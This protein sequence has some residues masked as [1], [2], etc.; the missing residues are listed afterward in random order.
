MK[1]AILVCA[2]AVLA[3]LVTVRV[4]ADEGI[5]QPAQAQELQPGS[6][7]T[8]AEAVTTTQAV[9]TTTETTTET[10]ITE[11]GPVTTP[12]VMTGPATTEATTTTVIVTTTI[13]ITQ[14]QI[15]SETEPA[16]QL[17]LTETVGPA[18]VTFNLD[19]GYT[20]DPILVSVQAGGPFSAAGLGP[21]CSG[22]VAGAPTASVEWS[23]VADF[24]EFFFISDDDPTLAIQTPTG[25]IFCND[26]PNDVLLDP[27]I[28]IDAPPPGL[29]HIWVGSYARSQRIPGLLVISRNPAQ[30]IG[31][32][33]LEDFIQREPIP[34]VV[35]EPAQVRATSLP[36]ATTRLAETGVPTLQPG[37]TPVNA[38]VTVAGVIAAFD[39]PIRGAVCPGFINSYIDYSFTWAGTTPNLR[40]LFEGDADASLLVVGP[41]DTVYC[42]DDVAGK[43]NLNP[44]ANIVNP[45]AGTYLVYVGRIN[46]ELTVSGMLTVV[47]STEQLPAVLTAIR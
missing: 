13:A 18:L 30:N 42:N 2:A 11:T 23:G 37:A 44:M 3:V 45:P 25:Q 15:V 12:P 26:D 31:T 16:I 19:A 20:L 35:V 34:E 28:Q 5:T 33:R 43:E 17:V 6:G 39:L 7:V 14:V 36:T 22:Y 40:I 38:P 24:I 27:V 32:V 10:A 46:P 8:T 47:E 29:Y 41:G 4:F 21:G 1:R 9:T